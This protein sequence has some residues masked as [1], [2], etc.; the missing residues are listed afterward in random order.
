M[1]IYG[2]ILFAVGVLFVLV[3]AGL[4]V[5]NSLTPRREVKAQA[6]QGILK[7]IFDFILS[8]LKILVDLV[9]E[10]R[11]AKG[12]LILVVIGIALIVL[13]FLVLKA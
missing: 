1:T 12:G 2:I 13:P 11:A 10:D 6:D 5:Y 4:I 3:G 7:T 8:L 9:G